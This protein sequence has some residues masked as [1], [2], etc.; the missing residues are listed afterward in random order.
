[1]QL[2]EAGPLNG[3]WARTYVGLTEEK[4]QRI[5]K[6]FHDS[7]SIPTPRRIAI[8]VISNTWVTLFGAPSS[9]ARLQ[10]WSTELETVP[11]IDTDSGGPVHNPYL[12]PIDVNQILG[13]S[14][15]H[16]LRL[17]WSKARLFSPVHCEEYK[18]ATYGELLDDILTGIMHKVLRVSDVIDAS[19]GSLDVKLPVQL[20]AVGPT[21]H[22]PAVEQ[23]LKQR[24]IE[25]QEA[26][27]NPTKRFEVTV[28]A[29]GGSDQIAVVG[30]SGRFPGSDTVE[31][32]W[33][34][35]LAGKNHIKKIPESR[36][37]LEHFYDPTGKKK[38]STTAQHGAFLD[39]P[40]L[41][42]HRLFNVSP[43]ESSQMDPMVRLSLAT[44]YEAL[45]SAGYFPGGT[46]S[47]QTNRIATYLGQTGE[48]W[49]EMLNNEGVDIYYVPSTCR[50]FGPGRI[51]YQ[52]KF[53]GGSFALDSACASSTTAISLACSALIARECD[54]A[55][56]GGGSV[57]VSPNSFSGLSKANM[58]STT[59]GCRTYHDDA[60]GYCRGEA[61]AMVV[62][63][64]LEDAEAD[65]DNILGVIRGST[66]TYSHTA[67][68]ITHPCHIAQERV[69]NE[70]LRQSSLD[71]AEIS[72]VEMHGTGTQAGDLEEMESV[73]NVMGQKRSRDN[74]LVVGAVKA[75]IGHG[76]AAAG[77][78]SLIKVLMMM[79]D[80]V[81][82]PQPGWPFTLN[83]NFPSLDKLNIKI[84]TKQALD[85]RASPRGDGKIKVLV[86][87]LDASVSNNSQPNVPLH[88]RR[89]STQCGIPE[90]PKISPEQA[91][92]KVLQNQ[93]GNTSLAV[94]EPP[95][96]RTKT[97]DPRGG[98][99]VT[100]SART[101]PALQKNR[102][103][104]FGYL[105]RN[106]HTKLA[107]LAY[108]TTARRMH[109]SLRLAYVGKT[110]SDSK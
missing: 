42:D 78:T 9:L 61:V 74:S 110:T 39:E 29:R 86:N 27:D 77:V 31:G 41:F 95:A 99:V 106:P 52:Y 105:E 104:L 5:L 108:T 23:L 100:L 66:R 17:D 93:G 30:M 50:A 71:P 75:S 109:E 90:T 46:P 12:P 1:M 76:E 43:R 98:H 53:G 89:S 8:G 72:Y 48:D 49:H 6:E 57:L 15:I 40:G 55:L 91:D 3:M 45:E 44:S 38:N 14:G 96:P 22:K 87:S 58:L 32:F 11:S 97:V 21:G 101:L 67:S 83:R 102:E 68:S 88:L 18:H 81:I 59:G 35:L 54:T 19:I 28:Q 26:N 63:K 24:H 7:Q 10:A 85:L 37:D 47:T 70:V 80:R 34:D 82:P 79:R 65:N 94:E 92:F 103:R 33:K 69:Y 25:Y 2:V 56:A 13:G 62:L 60:D 4:A 107:D 84:A 73:I 51:N 36:F 64:R 20:I 16:D